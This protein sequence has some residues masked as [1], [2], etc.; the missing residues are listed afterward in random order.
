MYDQMLNIFEIWVIS[1]LTTGSVL[2]RNLL[3]SVICNYFNF[4]KENFPKFIQ[5]KLN[6]PTIQ[7]WQYSCYP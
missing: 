3:F 4:S 1:Y 2:A 7:T 6:H 5:I